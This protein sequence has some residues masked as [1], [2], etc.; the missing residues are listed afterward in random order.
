MRKRASPQNSS[1]EKS[2]EAEV[3]VPTTKLVRNQRGEEEE[4][5]ESQEDGSR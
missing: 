2:L 1:I 4:D 5:V 3:E